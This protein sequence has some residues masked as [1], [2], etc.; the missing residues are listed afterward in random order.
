MK[1][2]KHYET[3]RFSVT[4]VIT[5]GV[6]AASGVKDTVLVPE[7]TLVEI[8]DQKTFTDKTFSGNSAWD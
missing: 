4:Q 6:F 8:E 5:E 2:K 7:G 3:P 1:E